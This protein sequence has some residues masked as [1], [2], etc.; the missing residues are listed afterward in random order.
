MRTWTGP[1]QNDVTLM[2][3]VGCGNTPRE[4]QPLRPRPPLAAGPMERCIE[5]IKED[6]AWLPSFD[7]EFKR[8]LKKV[9]GTYGW[10]K[11]PVNAVELWN[12][13]WEGVSD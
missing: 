2:L 7:P 1:W 3:T 11:G 8:Y 9:V 5:G 10:P 4:Q 6:L 12:E 13:P